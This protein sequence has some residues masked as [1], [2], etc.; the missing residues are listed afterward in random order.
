MSI[1]EGLETLDE[2]S[3]CEP[4]RMVWQMRCFY[5]P[6]TGARTT[7]NVM[8]RSGSPDRRYWSSVASMLLCQTSLQATNSILMSVPLEPVCEVQVSAP[9]NRR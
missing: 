1:R 7:G 9:P 3:Y 8:T 6:E 4:V 2:A 5:G